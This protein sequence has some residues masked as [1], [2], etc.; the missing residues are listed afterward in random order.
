MATVL[1]RRH[2]LRGKSVV[3]LVKRLRGAQDIRG[4]MAR[5]ARDVRTEEMP[6]VD[7]LAAIKRITGEEATDILQMAGVEGP[8]TDEHLQQ[9][10]HCSIVEAN[11]TGQQLIPEGNQV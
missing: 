10:L 6:R 2:S 9:C 1:R 3:P 7:L 4:P 5:L 8:P 11:E